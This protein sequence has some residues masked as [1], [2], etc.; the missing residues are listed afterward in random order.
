MS[1]VIYT[2]IESSGKSLLLSRQA[3]IVRLRNKRWFKKTGL[4]RTMAFNTPMS[5]KFID[6]IN[7]Y[8]VYLFFRNLDDII[9]LEECDI[10][11]D[12]VIKYFPASQNSLS[13]EQLHFITQGAKSGICLWGAS[14][15]FSQVH[16]QFRRLVNEVFVV[17]KLVG[18]KRPMKTAPPVHFVWGICSKCPVQ[19]QSFKGDDSSMVELTT[20]WYSFA[21]FKFFFILQCDIERFDTSFKIPMSKLPVKKV[22]KQVEICD[23]DGH[24]R[25][26][27]V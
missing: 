10:F 6:E 8:S 12:E 13:N 25:A 18:S 20:G 4:K 11:I 21:L 5:Q 23:E 1:K 27:Y 26:Y 7:Q 14:Q 17:K 9:Y 24:T 2:G 15:D 16:K 19:P 22:R 3:E